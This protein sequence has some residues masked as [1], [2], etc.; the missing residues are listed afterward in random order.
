MN[1]RHIAYLIALILP[2]S[3]FG[4]SVKSDDCNKIK[5][6]TFYFY[7]ANAQNGFAVIR[8][9]SLQEEIN[10]KTSDTSFWKINWTNACEFNLRFIRKS[11]PI[12][13]EEKDFYNAHVTVVKITK[14]T[15]GYYVFKGGLDSINSKSAMTDTLWFKAR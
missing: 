2:L 5:Y 14:I 12:S 4:Q 6:G 3:M 9:K 1:K 10:L 15:R 13:D 11:H 7:P 8:K